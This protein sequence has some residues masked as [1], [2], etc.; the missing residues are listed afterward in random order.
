M[1]LDDAPEH[2]FIEAMTPVFEGAPRFVARLAAA[3]PFG[4]PDLL[5]DR[6]ID[7]ALSMPEDEQIELVDAHPR[8]GAPPGSVSALSFREQGYD[9][10]ADSPVDI[11]TELEQLN[12]AYEQRFGFRYCVFVAGRSRP[13][14]IPGFE[15]ALGRRRDDELPRALRDVVAIARARLEQARAG[16]TA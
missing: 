4:S 3:R 2:E 8:I 13:A 5:F 10:S 12:D 1:R 11:A 16:V 6:A 7:I 9:R 14:L 15:E